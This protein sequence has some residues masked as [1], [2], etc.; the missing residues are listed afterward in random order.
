MPIISNLERKTGK[1]RGG[2][3]VIYAVLITGAVSMLYPF[4]LM[5]RMTTMDAVDKESL[6]PLP[7]FWWNADQMARKYLGGQYLDDS[8]FAWIYD[9]FGAVKPDGRQQMRWR[10][11]AEA[12][13]DKNETH[14]W[15]EYFAPLEQLPR[16]QLA[17][18]VADYREF[19][20]SADRRFVYPS[21]THLPGRGFNDR[22][23]AYWLAKKEGVPDKTYQYFEKPRV[24]WFRR[25]WTPQFDKAWRDWQAWL[26]WL[27]PAERMAFS[28][29]VP[30]QAFLKDRYKSNLTDLNQAHQADYASFA[31]PLFH[32]TPPAAGT[33]RRDD[34]ERFVATRYPLFWQQLKPGVAAARQA[35]WLAWLAEK[36]YVRTPADF[37]KFTGAEDMTLPA[38]MPANEVAAR[39]WCDFVAKSVPWDQ[40]ELLH[41]E[42]AFA[43]FLQQKYDLDRLNAAWGSRVTNWSEL[44]LPIVEADFLTVSTYAGSIRRELTTGNF[45]KVL[46]ELTVEG[47]AFW[48]TL[49]IIALSLVTSLTINPIA[50]YALSR[51]RLKN[52][53]KILLFF[54]ATMALP[55]EVAM[56]PSFLLVRDLNLINTYWA[57]IL[58]H[59]ANAYSIFLL[60]GFFDSLPAELYE[61]A[62]IDGASEWTLFTQITIPLSLPILAVTALGTTTAAYNI[63]IP[64]VMYITD[65]N[66][67]PIATKIYQ[68]NQQSS[69]GGMGMAALVLASVFPLCVFI[70]FNRVIMRGIILPSFK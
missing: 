57:L 62:T 63:F 59:A 23:I 29:H 41:C 27:E 68:I 40:R 61:A 12:N 44:R 65:Q 38:S 2:L 6:S 43:Q 37:K 45:S 49:L 64:A 1:G 50:A 15:Q 31:K 69:G 26:Q 11:F 4:L 39:W 14:F 42:E 60:K 9:S 30:W 36:R 58:P 8:Q 33:K 46:R 20:T 34:W 53:Q 3:G 17:R 32:T 5:L 52:T 25:D 21:F 67:W 51:F 13:A 55:H 19:C 7:A 66:M 35:E 24:D 28:S 47:R 54:L 18:R 16:E 70:F 10:A 56:I 48:N 22:W